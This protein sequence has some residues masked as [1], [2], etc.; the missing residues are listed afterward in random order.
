MQDLSNI[1]EEL[2]TLSALKDDQKMGGFMEQSFDIKEESEDILDDL[3]DI[4]ESTREEMELKQKLQQYIL[5]TVSL[6]EKIF[7]RV[8]ALELFVQEI[9]QYAEAEDLIIELQKDN[10]ELLI[11]V[12]GKNPENLKQSLQ[13]AMKNKAIEQLETDPQKELTQ[14]TQTTD[15]T[16]AEIKEKMKKQ[17]FSKRQS[18]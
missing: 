10:P 13:D 17:F 1:E 8:Q 3:N 18:M 16:T 5:S 14:T 15:P 4:D 11:E 2:T 9:R 12:Y 7:T 6:F